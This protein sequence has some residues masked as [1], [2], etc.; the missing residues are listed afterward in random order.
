MITMDVL[1]VMQSGSVRAGEGKVSGPVDRGRMANLVPLGPGSE[2]PL[3]L[4]WAG[5]SGNRF[6]PAGRVGSGVPLGCVRSGGGAAGWR[7]LCVAGVLVAPWIDVKA[8]RGVGCGRGAQSGLFS[9]AENA[10]KPEHRWTLED[11]RV[12]AGEDVQDAME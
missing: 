1:S 10:V 7:T 5:P 2:Q 4:I 12:V 11:L 8:G 3:S 9:S 6:A